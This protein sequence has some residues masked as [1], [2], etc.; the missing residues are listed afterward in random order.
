MFDANAQVWRPLSWAVAFSVP[1]C[2][3]LAPAAMA[4]DGVWDSINFSFGGFLRTETNDKV[5]ERQA[6]LPPELLPALTGGLL[7]ATTDWGTPGT[8]FPQILGSDADEPARR[9]DEIPNRESD[10][11]LNMLR[12]EFETKIRFG[13]NWK[14]TARM[15]AVYDD[16]LGYEEFDASRLTEI[17]D[18]QGI[19]GGDPELYQNDVNYF[20]YRVEGDRNPVPLEYAGEN[21]LIDFPAL[22]LEYANGPL[23]LRFGNMQIAWRPGPAAALGPGLCTGRVCRRACPRAGYSPGL[24]AHRFHSLGLVREAIPPDGAG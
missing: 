3:G 13:N 6:Y 9:G 17:N 12:G 2:L 24:P 22:V 20:E 21:Y 14:I 5:V 8:E 18:G 23:S 7:P 10:W 19:V 1:L 15:R 4:D 11:N 16:A